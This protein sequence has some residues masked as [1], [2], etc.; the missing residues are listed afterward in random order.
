MRPPIVLIGM[1]G[2]GKSTI[3]KRLA[4]RLGLPFVDADRELELRSGVSI[5]TIFEIE[6]EAGFREREARLLAELCERSD[7]VIATGGGAVLRPENR[8]VLQGRPQV[9]YLEATVAELWSRVRHDR[10]R[11]LLQSG[12]ARERLGLLLR[13]R[14]PLYEQVADK[15]VRGHRQSLERFTGEVLATLDVGG[16]SVAPGE[17]AIPHADGAESAD[18]PTTPANESAPPSGPPHHA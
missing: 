18:A 11:P 15:T 1:P 7:V 16:D 6:G 9:I 3:G 10:R 12:D 4:V 13:E 2:S 8:A 5:A 14:A 17:Q